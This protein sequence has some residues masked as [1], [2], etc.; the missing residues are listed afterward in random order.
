MTD[1][2]DAASKDRLIRD[3]MDTFEKKDARLLAPFFADDIVFENYG[4]SPLHGRDNLV[5]MWNGVFGNFANVKF[6]TLNQ[7]VNGDVVIAEQV[8]GLGLPGRPIAPIRNLA[9]YEVHDGKIT[10]WRDYTNMAYA[11]TLL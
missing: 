3:F 7:A 8:H 9:V 4:D 2:N 11:R 10:A 6:E 5:A 1:T